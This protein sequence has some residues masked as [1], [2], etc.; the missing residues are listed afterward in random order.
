VDPRDEQLG[1]VRALGSV[2]SETPDQREASELRDRARA[3]LDDQG[4]LDDRDVKRMIALLFLGR[5]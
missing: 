4:P 5:A 3:H 2:W 1:R